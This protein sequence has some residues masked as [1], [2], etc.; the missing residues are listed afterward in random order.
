MSL[1]A[2]LVGT[3]TLVAALIGVFN[4]LI[5]SRSARLG[6]KTAQASTL[7][8]LREGVAEPPSSLPTQQQLVNREEEV[9]H[10]LARIR[11]GEAVLAIEGSTGVGK[12]TVALEVAHRLKKDKP[13]EDDPDLSGHAFVWID[14]EREGMSLRAICNGIALLTGDQS[15]TTAPDHEKLNVLRAHLARNK[16]VLLL[17]NVWPL[18][19]AEAEVLHELITTVPAG[20]IVIASVN[21]SG[22]VDGHHLLV[23]D[24]DQEHVGDL[25]AREVERLGLG[26]DADFDA[27][28]ACRLR[29]LV[30]GNPRMIQWFVKTLK[31]TSRPV[32][33]QFEAVERGEGLLQMFMPVWEELTGDCRTVLGA[34][35]L[36]KG[37]AIAAQLEIACGL[38]PT[39]VSTQLDE[40][41]AA[42]LVRTIRETGSPNLYACAPGSQ[43]FVQAATPAEDTVAFI[44]RLTA[45]YLRRFT[46]DWED[47]AGAIPHMGAIQVLIAELERLG[48]DDE[49]Q[50]L[51][52]V[53]LDIYF[54]LG[55][56]DDRIAAGEIAYKSAMTAENYAAA[57]RACA[58]IANTNAI[59]GEIGKARE[60]SSLG[61]AAAKASNE[62][63]EIARQKRSEGFLHYRDEQPH[64]ALEATEGAEALAR[65]AGDL[66]NVV[67][68]LGLRTAAHWYLGEIQQAEQEARQCLRICEE[69]DWQRSLAYPLR[70]LAELAIRRRSL[71]EAGELLDRAREIAVRFEDRRQLARVNLTAARL[72]LAGG[73]P[74]SARAPASLAVVE[75]TTLGLPAEAREA[76]ALRAAARWARIL[77]P[78][79]WYYA[80]RRPL[81]LTSAPVG[82]D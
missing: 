30:G 61:I 49:L 4:A 14:G 37:R 44:E 31:E 46:A 19:Q 68:I 81:R 28:F 26:R 8:P 40:L 33:A 64:A 73:D 15:L 50:A 12:S 52:G 82:G 71:G 76:G 35:G 5:Q 3:L 17:D 54:T 22:A 69:I 6:W 1:S 59:Q 74:G 55:L 24:L 39:E 58:M 72:N 75:A 57:S 51:L 48:R 41:A 56:F 63:R 36:L 13:G 60:A 2:S 43:R 16:T 9:D 77:P 29:K 21:K 45:Y 42:G 34:C 10:A 47:A 27:D 62:P 18:D 53:T 32:E 23:E 25:I 80:L 79:R 11:A 65:E 66:N 38:S 70:D 78:L 20:S 7:P 67:D